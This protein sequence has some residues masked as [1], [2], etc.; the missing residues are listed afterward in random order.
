MAIGNP[1]WSE[2][3]WLDLDLEFKYE[4]QYPSKAHIYDPVC[5]VKITHLQQPASAVFSFLCN[6]FVHQG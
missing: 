2:S 3:S 5:S 6:I 1:A 4:R